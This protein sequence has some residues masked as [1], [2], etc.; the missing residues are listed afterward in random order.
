MSLEYVCRVGTPE[1]QVREEVHRAHDARALRGELE[2][3][4]FHVFEIRRKS[5]LARLGR[6]GLG[7]RRQRIPLSRF[8]IFNQELAALLHSGLPILQALSMMAERERDP[9]FREILGGVRDQVKTG[10]DLSEAFQLHGDLFPPL[11]APTLKAGERTGELEQV[12]RRFIRYQELVLGARKRIVSALV[13]PCVLIG[14]SMLLIGVM[15]IYV[16][17]KFTEF[18]EALDSELPLLTRVIVGFST[19]LQRH[20]LLL[21]ASVAGLVL[22]AMRWKR[23]SL[24]A[25]AADRIKLRLPIVGGIFRQMAIS[26]F[27]RSLS[28]LLAGGIPVVSALENSV[29]AIG[30]RWVRERI[31]PTVGRVRQGEALH[32][33]LEATGEAP[34]I[35]VDMIKIGES[36]GS[37]D[38]MLGSASDFLD[39]EVETRMQR[40]LTLLEPVMLVLMGVIVAILLISIYLP[41]FSLL[42]Q[43]QA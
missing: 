10:K 22:L 32:S 21:L 11:Y 34:E 3:R 6:G 29:G 2:N 35:A 40:L 24:G 41:M 28:T 39:Q 36:T 9:L 8:L 17:P 16:V 20:W 19:S 18:F 13:Y 1:G 33:A 37:L 25:L 14:L 30:N 15:T 5:L 26:E 31:A 12:L 23:T 42:G 7:R 43:M 38:E 4:G 27:C